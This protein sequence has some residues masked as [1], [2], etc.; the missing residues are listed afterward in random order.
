MKTLNVEQVYDPDWPLDPA[1]QNDPARYNY[2]VVKVTNSTTPQLHR[3]LSA[4]EL[5]VYCE[6]DDWEVTI[7]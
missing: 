2:S 7:T 3:E 4:A 5:D 1:N 6:S